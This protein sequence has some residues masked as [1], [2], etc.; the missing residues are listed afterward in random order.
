MVTLLVII[1]VIIHY[2]DVFQRDSHSRMS[3][4][5]AI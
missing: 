5:N 3:Q 4:L 2:N 1:N